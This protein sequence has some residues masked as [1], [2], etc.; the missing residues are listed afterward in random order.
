MKYEVRPED[1]VVIDRRGNRVPPP[2]EP[3]LHGWLAARRFP[4]VALLAFAEFLAVAFG[5]VSVPALVLVGG[6]ALAGYLWVGRR[7][8]QPFVRLVLWIIAMAQGLLALLSVIIPVGIVIAAI[9]GLIVL[10]IAVMVALGD[11]H[12]RRPR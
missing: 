10:I 9:V 4:A 3:G 1:V 2:P 5:R 12:A 11:R 8:R 7:V 6:G